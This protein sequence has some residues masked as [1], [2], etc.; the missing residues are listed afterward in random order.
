MD[1][2]LEW[3]GPFSWFGDAA[4]ML[5]G[6]AEAA[7]AGVYA[8][9]A[10]MPD[11]D[12]VYYVG[13]TRKN[14]GDRHWEHWREYASGAYSIHSAEEFYS[15]RHA[16]I[17]RG[18][19]YRRPAF[20]LAASVLSSLDRHLEATVAFLRPMRIWLAELPP[21]TRLQRRIEGAI[22]RALYQQLGPAK[23][24]QEPKMRMELRKPHEP[25]IRV[26]T[27]GACSLVGIPH[28]LEA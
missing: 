6:A 9:S 20:R 18:F 24:F 21:D 2:E 3:K 10:K 11:G 23:D 12:W 13:Q 8:W 17:H 19:A 1:V 16:C 5:F 28:T 22:V 7:A 14:F 15:G 27:R 26:W 4:P 25:P